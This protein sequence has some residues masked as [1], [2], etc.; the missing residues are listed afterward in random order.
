MKVLQDNIVKV[1]KDGLYV[2]KKCSACGSVLEISNG[3]IL[4]EKDKNE[5]IEL[6]CLCCGSTLQLKKYFAGTKY[7]I[8]EYSEVVAKFSDEVGHMLYE[9]Q[10]INRGYGTQYIN[11]AAIGLIGVETSVRVIVYI[12]EYEC[13]NWQKMINNTVYYKE[14]DLD[15]ASKILCDSFY[16]YAKYAQALMDYVRKEL[17]NY[18]RV[19]MN[20]YYCPKHSLYEEDD[21]IIACFRGGDFGSMVDVDDKHYRLSRLKDIEDKTIYTP[22][23]KSGLEYVGDKVE[24]ASVNIANALYTIACT[25]HNNALA[26]RETTKRIDCSV[27]GTVH[28]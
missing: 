13:G 15:I 4:S 12:D 10:E 25:M 23:V 1:D 8:K 27:H 9:L 28:Y 17:T 14:F 5:D 19:K 24:I 7:N 20:G 21:S 22:D 18:E 3:D 11:I 2:K 26:D 6:K 16:D